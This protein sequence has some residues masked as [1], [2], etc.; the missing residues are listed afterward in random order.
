MIGA[1]LFGFGM[2]LEDVCIQYYLV[3]C[4][5]T[6]SASAIAASNIARCPITT[7]FCLSGFEVYRRLG[8]DG[9][10]WQVAR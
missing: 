8:Y 1:I 7:V 3:D 10:L 5:G 2:V 9:M 6:W 4:F